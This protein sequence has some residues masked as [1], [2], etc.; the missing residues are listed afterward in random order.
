[1]DASKEAPVVGN[2]GDNVA[3]TVVADI[4][5]NQDEF[6]DDLE[7]NGSEAKAKAGADNEDEA[8]TNEECSHWEQQ[9][10][11]QNLE[12]DSAQLKTLI[13]ELIKE[14]QLIPKGT[15]NF[16][17]DLQNTLKFVQG[18]LNKHQT[19]I[20]QLQAQY[21]EIRRGNIYQPPPAAERAAASTNSRAEPAVTPS[22]VSPTAGARTDV[23]IWLSIAEDFMSVHNVRSEARVVAATLSLDDTAS[24]LV[25]ANERH[26]EAN[27]HPF[28][29]EEFKA[30]MLT[31]FLSQPP[32]LEVRSRLENIQCGD[33]PVR[34][35]A[36]EFEKTL[37]LLKT[38]FPE[39]EVIHQ[40]FE[41]IK[42][43]HVVRGEHQWKTYKECKEHVIDTDVNFRAYMSHARAQ[44]PPSA[45]GP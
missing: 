34:E 42:R 33:Q 22:D 2:E 25:Y 17:L 12:A 36:K 7:I 31:A 44:Q 4:D 1:M 18:Q 15:S 14:V 11:I 32:A 41:H 26:A 27:G 23:K 24:K 30:A 3:A 9:C 10:C 29:W 13:E 37:S 28:G 5:L 16:I 43:V 20:S 35:Y 45:E 21:K 38:A 8:N 6:L 39:S 19:L 40:F